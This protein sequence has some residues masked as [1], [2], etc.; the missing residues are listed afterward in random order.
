MPQRPANAWCA[1]SEPTFVL[2]TPADR[3]AVLAMHE[4]LFDEDGLLGFALEDR[5]AGLDLLLAQSGRWGEIYLIRAADEVAGYIV[6]TWGFTVE[7]GGPFVLI[8]ELYLSPPFRGRGWGRVALAFVSEMARQRG[9]RAV[10]LEVEHH[11]THAEQL[12]RRA[13]FV[14]H[15]TRT[16]FELRL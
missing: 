10:Q 14:P 9:Q 13:G 4:A 16:T 15:A 3:A 12:Y 7:L 1:M 8:D 5:A 6:T 11:N 2:A